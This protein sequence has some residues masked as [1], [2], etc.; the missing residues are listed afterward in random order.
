MEAISDQGEDSGTEG[1]TPG[2]AKRQIMLLFEGLWPADEQI[3]STEAAALL[4]ESGY[5]KQDNINQEEFDVL[6]LMTAARVK[7]L[8]S[9]GTA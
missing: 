8:E 9:E 4:S 7:T 1:M 5:D 2:A 6:L 3:R